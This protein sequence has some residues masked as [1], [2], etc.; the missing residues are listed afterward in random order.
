M[1]LASR[2][3]ADAAKPE[4]GRPE[5]GEGAPPRFRLTPDSRADAADRRRA[6]RDLATATREGL[7]LLH[8]QPRLALADLHP[9][10][11]EALIRWPHRKRGLVSPGVF[12]PL[13]ERSGQALEICAWALASA[14][15]D[16][17]AWPPAC[18]VSVSIAARRIDTATLLGHITAALEASGI[19]PERLEI[20]LGESLLLDAGEETF[21]ALSAVRD[22]G[23]GIALDDFGTGVASLSMLRRLPLTALKLDRS[24]VRDLPDDREEAAIVRAT[25]ETGHALGL[26]VVAEG[27]ETEPQRA[28][29]VRAGC[30]LG[31]GILFGHPLDAGQIAARLTG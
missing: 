27:I 26:T 30:D 5:P 28:F 2:R 18:I 9:V 14:S 16:A 19:V 23:V 6:E 25:I 7:L 29:L 1:L 20:G 4:A 21:F 15:R 17:T 24:M 31:Q 12:M 22:L 10:G 11:A 3:A 13:A 8:Y